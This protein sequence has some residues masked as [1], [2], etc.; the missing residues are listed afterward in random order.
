M[1]TPSKGQMKFRIS[2]PEHV[3]GPI[4][5]K[6]SCSMTY[7]LDNSSKSLVPVPKIVKKNTSKGL[8]AMEKPAKRHRRSS[9]HQM[10]ACCNCKRRRKRCDGK[11]PTCSL[12][13]RLGLECT[14]VFAPTGREIKRD[15]IDTLEKRIEE[16]NNVVKDKELQTIDDQQNYKELGRLELN[17]QS[18]TSCPSD[19]FAA[20][21]G[22]I[23]VGAADDPRYIGEASIYPIAKAI[24]H[25]ISCY[26][27]KQFP[28][29]SAVTIHDTPSTVDA[30]FYQPSRPLAESY[31]SIY[32]EAIQIQY[33]FLDWTEVKDWFEEV[34]R[35]GVETK[36]G[37]AKFFIYMIFALGVQ[38]LNL[39]SGAHGCTKAYY[40]MAFESLCG[41]VE[42][43]TIHAVQAFLMLAVF[44]QKIPDGASVWQTTGMAIR[45]AVALGMHRG[46]DDFIDQTADDLRSR[47]F[48]SAYGIERMNGLVLG[49]PFSIS[50]IDIDTPLPKETP[51]TK[52]AI[53]VIKLRQIQSSISTFIYKPARLLGNPEEIDSTRIQIVLELNNWAR[54]FPYKQS[55]HIA[56]ET[57]AWPV[58]S[59]HNSLTILLRP[60][61]LEV[62]RLREKAP[63]NYIRWFQVFADSASTICLSYKTMYLR[64]FFRCMWLTIHGCFIAG[65]SFLYCLWLDQFM[66]VLKWKRS[67]IIYDTINACS[68]ILYVL[69]ERW[70]GGVM[71]RDTFEHL[72]AIMKESLNSSGYLKFES[73]ID[74]AD[75]NGKINL[76]TPQPEITDELDKA[77][78]GSKDMNISPEYL[79]GLQDDIQNCKFPQTTS[80]AQE[81]IEDTD[82]LWEFLDTTGDKFLKSI[83]SDMEE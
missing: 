12:C 19:N 43:T 20:R 68:S 37:D 50:D 45:A 30:P 2:Q 74:E 21:V 9:K 28:P 72:E 11:Y 56:L 39:P 5:A 63:Q 80:K 31:L 4:P 27:A 33:P 42:H 44:S 22:M 8:G 7:S 57:K 38:L 70:K 6:E 53:Q 26:S 35:N 41:I 62:A 52:L 46:Y 82:K 16:L 18:S 73:K 24:A 66:H 76:P 67:S 58:I 55:A 14:T 81:F 32:H 23:T 71:F 36:N 78:L 29:P 48:W 47:I 34:M 40:D 69:A 54:N 1:K 51:D 83:F 75:N 64:G 25:S 3:K 59:Y 49:R 61:V 13:K 65:I 17:Y 79:Q 77:I 60:V 15:Y 10:A